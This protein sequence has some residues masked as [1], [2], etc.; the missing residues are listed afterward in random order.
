M[1]EAIGILDALSAKFTFRRRPVPVPADLRPD[2]RISLLVLILRKCCRDGQSSLRR[3]HVLSWAI[4]GRESREA[5]VERL[6]GQTAPDEVLVRFEPA[7]NRAIDLARGYGLIVRVSGN[8]V[9][10]TLRGTQFADELERLTDVLSEER[11]F[12]SRL[13]KGVTEQAVQRLVKGEIIG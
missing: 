13:G 12:L 6:N 5:F 9:R 8:K 11:T 4:R 1:E 7:L 3:L 10:L 2:W